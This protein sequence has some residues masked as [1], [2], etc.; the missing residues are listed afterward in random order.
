MRNLEINGVPRARDLLA[1]VACEL[2]V[3]EVGT[4]GQKPKNNMAASGV[5]KVLVSFYR[6]GEDSAFERHR[7]RDTFDLAK[8][9]SVAAVKKHLTEF[10]GLSEL[11]LKFGMKRVFIFEGITETGAEKFVVH[12]RHIDVNVARKELHLSFLSHVMI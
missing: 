7:S 11:A 4:Q 1:R 12:V 3:D 10:L 5:V 9:S 8:Q 6:S 2:G